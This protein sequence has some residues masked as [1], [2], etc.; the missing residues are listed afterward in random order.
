MFL[1]IL[2]QIEKAFSGANAPKKAENKG[3]R[4]QTLTSKPLIAL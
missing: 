2:I 4:G 3:F 1:L